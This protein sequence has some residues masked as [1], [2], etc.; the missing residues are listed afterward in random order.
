MTAIPNFVFE[1]VWP[2]YSHNMLKHKPILHQLFSLFLCFQLFPHLS[3]AQESAAEPTE[4]EQKIASLSL[5]KKVGQ[6]FIIGFPQTSVDERLSQHLITYHFNAFLLFKRNI[7]SLSQLENLNQS[8]YSLGARSGLPLPIVAVDQEGGFVSRIPIQ[9]M[10]PSALSIG[11]TKSTLVAEKLGEE[12]GKILLKLGF[13][14]NL[15]PVLDIS[16]PNEKSFIGIRSFG[17]DPQLVADLGTAYS[18]GLQKSLVVPTAK[19]FPGLGSIKEDPHEIT[20]SR[21]DSFKELAGQDLVPFQSYSSLGRYTAI[22]LSHMSYPHLDESNEPA[23]FSKKII[24]TWLRKELGYDGLVITDDLHMKASSEKIPL[25]EG[26]IRALEAGADM[27]MLSWSFRE[28]A[29][30]YQKVLS[31]Y[32]TG[33]LSMA[34][35]DEKLKRILSVKAQFKPFQTRNLASA[36]QVIYSNELHAV[37]GLAFQAKLSSFALPLAD[38]PEKICIYSSQD[39]FLSGF[40]EV[41]GAAH[42][43][44]FKMHPLLKAPVLEKSL[45][46]NGCSANILTTYSRHQ[47]QLVS[48]LSSKQKGRVALINFGSSIFIKETLPFLAKLEVLAPYEKAGAELAKHLRN[49]VLSTE[50]TSLL[51]GFELKKI[52]LESMKELTDVLPKA[53][54]LRVREP[55]RA[56][57]ARN[58]HRPSFLSPVS[59]RPE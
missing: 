52:N 49:K 22:M 6:L 59:S 18:K 37:E 51:N 4:I 46:S 12:V 36:P 15:A 10:V 33:R 31:A 54:S 8:L 28:Q 16:S 19:H 35:L 1:Y 30:T 39:R 53:E 43:R 42:V 2:W 9:P 24:S 45:Q 23:S 29:N 50:K 38:K 44:T 26:A 7:A 40:R 58:F 27:I 21:K 20:I 57:E 3:T 48:Q 32:K 13:N 41:Y 55:S 14:M 17:G 47:A 34:D 56:V 5:E 11:L 25:T